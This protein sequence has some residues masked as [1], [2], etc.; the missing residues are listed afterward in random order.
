MSDCFYANHRSCTQSKNVQLWR[1][2][3]Q[4][5]KRGHVS[6]F[7]QKK[8]GNHISFPPS[9]TV[10]KRSGVM[11]VAYTSEIF[12][13]P[14][15]KMQVFVVEQYLG[16]FLAELGLFS[17]TEPFRFPRPAGPSHVSRAK[18]PPAMRNKRALGTKIN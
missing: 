13:D 1:F 9:T 12:P 6:N 10:L 18:T 2:V 8:K 17:S 11:Y 14:R 3:S 15:S 4:I 7:S 16:L 5:E